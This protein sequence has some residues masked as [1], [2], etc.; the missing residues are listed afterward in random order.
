MMT[1]KILP[2]QKIAHKSKKALKSLET[3]ED[4]A[5]KAE[6]LLTGLAD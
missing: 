5:Q 2:N 3:L 6:N 4:S 1:P